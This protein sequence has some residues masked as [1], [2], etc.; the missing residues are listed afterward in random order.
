VSLNT[1][2]TPLLVQTKALPM[3]IPNTTTSNPPA[4]KSFLDSAWLTLD[5]IR[6]EVHGPSAI[7]D[8]SQGGTPTIT[9]VIKGHPQLSVDRVIHCGYR[10]RG[11]EG[12]TAI[13]QGLRVAHIEKFH[14]NT[15]ISLTGKFGSVRINH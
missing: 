9:A 4:E 15:I 3:T 13:G 5:G 12:K 8:G 2:A 7:S 10:E 11:A 6:Y 1:E 14:E